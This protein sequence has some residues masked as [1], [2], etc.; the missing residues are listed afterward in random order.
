MRSVDLSCDLADEGLLAFVTAVSVSCGFTAGPPKVLRR[1]CEAA[2]RH[3]VSIGALAGA[4]SVDEL[5]YHLGALD[6]IAGAAGGEVRYVKAR[7]DQAEHVA[8]LVEAV[9]Q[10]DPGLPVLCPPGSRLSGHAREAGLKTVA[11]ASAWDDPPEDPA[12]AARRC[13]RLAANG[14][15]V[16]LNGAVA[17]VRPGSLSLSGATAEVARAARAALLAAG[18]EVRSFARAPSPFRLVV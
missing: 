13:V 17:W 3:G 4:R 14:E 9:W 5:L 10:Y 6:A 2:V 16:V 1:G 7:G 11:E 12:K 15:P 8:A 18:I